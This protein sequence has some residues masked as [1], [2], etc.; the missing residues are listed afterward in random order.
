MRWRVR[1]CGCSSVGV[2]LRPIAFRAVPGALV[3]FYDTRTMEV[4]GKSESKIT[5]W[6]TPYSGM[7]LPLAVMTLLQAPT[8]LPLWPN[9]APGSEARRN[10]PE[11][12]PHPWSIAHIYNPSLTVYLPESPN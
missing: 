11:T 7:L 12:K 8:V 3:E 10:E 1:P 6:R 5:T 9:G 4:S 2:A